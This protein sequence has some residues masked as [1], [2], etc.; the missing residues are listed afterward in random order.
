MAPAA[1]GIGAFGRQPSL[2]GLRWARRHRNHWGFLWSRLFIAWAT[3]ERDALRLHRAKSRLGGP[4][5]GVRSSRQTADRDR[6]QQKHRCAVRVTRPLPPSFPC[7]VRLRMR[8]RRGRRMRR[9]RAPPNCRRPPCR[10]P[11]SPPRTPRLTRRYR[12][13][14]RR[15]RRCIA[16]PQSSQRRPPPHR[17]PS[18]RPRRTHPT[19]ASRRPRSPSFWGMGTP[20]FAPVTLPPRACFMSAL[21]LREMGGQRCAWERPSIRLSLALLACAMFKAMRLRRDRGTAVLST[22]APPRRNV[23]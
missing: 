13:D 2:P 21:P 23:S 22:S 14:L 16:R 17:V 10:R 8:N 15:R 18:P 20:F 11:Q 7:R 6:S 1:C 9:W 19:P 4:I 3:C 12:P 5:P